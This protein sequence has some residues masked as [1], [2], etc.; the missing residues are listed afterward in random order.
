MHAFARVCTRLH[1]PSHF[2]TTRAIKPGYSKIFVYDVKGK[3]L[4][5]SGMQVSSNAWALSSSRWNANMPRNDLTSFGIAKMPE[6]L[7]KF[8]TTESFKGTILVLWIP[9][10][11]T[12]EAESTHNTKFLLRQPRCWNVYLRDFF[13]SHP[14][15]RGCPW[16]KSLSFSFN[17][18][19]G[20]A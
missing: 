17:L 4:T 20:K 7:W 13:C 8:N 15:G 11:A 19:H 1:A 9:R 18:A 12:S 3:F 2:A 10:R 5:C 6:L 14:S 16:W